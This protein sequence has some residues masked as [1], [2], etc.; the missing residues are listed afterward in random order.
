MWGWQ[1]VPPVRA[2]A[3]WWRLTPR[4]RGSL[5][6]EGWVYPMWRRLVMGSSHGVHILMSINARICS[7][8]P[9]RSLVDP[10]RE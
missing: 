2:S 7:M 1:C 5:E 9:R 3:V 10:K 4:Q 8:A 6:P